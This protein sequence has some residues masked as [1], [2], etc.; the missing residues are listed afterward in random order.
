MSMYYQGILSKYILIQKVE[1]VLTK[2]RKEI[3]GSIPP[4]P[5]YINQWIFVYKIT[6][7]VKKMIDKWPK[8][9]R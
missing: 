5:I 9:A 3:G 7:L 2:Y 8:T 1:F 6:K 4:Y